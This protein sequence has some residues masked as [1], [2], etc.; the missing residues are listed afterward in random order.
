MMQDIKR[1]YLWLM[2]VLVL[3]IVEQFLFG[4]DE[5]Y[6]LQAGVGAIQRLFSNADYATVLLVSIMTLLVQ[7]IGFAGLVGGRW[8]LWVAGFFAVEGMGEAHHI[9]KTIAHG[10]YFPGAV[11]AIAFVAVGARLLVAVIRELRAHP[12]PSRGA[13]ALVET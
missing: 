1:W 2:A 6:E 8:P 12:L 11:T 13:G 10:T 5:L 7:L 3:H 9:V 4:I